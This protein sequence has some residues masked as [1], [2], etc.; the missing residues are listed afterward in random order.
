VPTVDAN[1]GKVVWAWQTVLSVQQRECCSIHLRSMPNAYHYV[2]AHLSTQQNHV[3]GTLSSEKK[4]RSQVGL[5][6]TAACIE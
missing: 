2:T 4:P 6:S 3:L 1:S 5:F